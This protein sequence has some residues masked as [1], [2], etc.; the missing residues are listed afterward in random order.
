MIKNDKKQKREDLYPGGDIANLSREELDRLNYERKLRDQKSAG[1]KITP[2]HI[3]IF[4]V[5]FCVVGLLYAIPR[6]LWLNEDETSDY[7]PLSERGSVVADEVLPPLPR[8]RVYLEDAVDTRTSMFVAPATTVPDTSTLEADVE[9]QNYVINDSLSTPRQDIEGLLPESEII[10]T[11]EQ[12]A[13]DWSN[14]NV[15]GYISH[16]ADNFISAN[17]QNLQAWEEYRRPRITS[18]EWIEVSLADLE[19]ELTGANNAQADFIQTYNAPG[20]SDETFK[21]L[22]LVRESN[23][24]KISGELS[25]DI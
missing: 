6:M 13:R 22:I 21:R 4:A 25:I 7:I 9:E 16:Y 24:W 3:N 2:W 18:P 20:Y 17:G 14:K 12:W 5:S 8:E 23:G 11:P 1:R 19:V 15:D 10:N